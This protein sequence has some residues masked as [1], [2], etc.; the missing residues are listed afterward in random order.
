MG[1]F[2]VGS[3]YYRMKC[4]I[5]FTAIQN[6]PLMPT[7]L[8]SLKRALFAI[9]KDHNEVDRVFNIITEQKEY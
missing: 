8:K 7:K 9:L 3:Y 4:V 5:L 1:I 6:L 2:L